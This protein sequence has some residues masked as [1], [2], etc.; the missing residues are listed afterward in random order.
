MEI[1]DILFR[2]ALV[3]CILSLAGIFAYEMEK[4]IESRKEDVFE[5]IASR[6]GREL[7]SAF[8]LDPGTSFTMGFGENVGMISLPSDLSG[9]RFRIEVLPGM[10]VLR[11]RELRKIVAEEEC[12]VPSLPPTGGLPLNSTEARWISLGYGGFSIDAPCILEIDR[13]DLTDSPSLFI[14]P[15]HAEQD[16][17][18][19]AKIEELLSLVEEPGD[20]NPYWSVYVDVDE[21]VIHS[22]KGRLVMFENV[23]RGGWEGSIG[24]C[25]ALPRDADLS[26]VIDE[27]GSITYRKHAHEQD[28]GMIIIR[29]YAFQD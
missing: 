13:M 11:W 14:H 9:D 21:A 22:I 2:G 18:A 20:L 12:I 29:S 28:D 5:A 16:E 25:V 23:V 1:G 7:V 8:S 17:E 24:T 10:V 27:N 6:F 19:A 4:G 26:Q 3:L 15:G